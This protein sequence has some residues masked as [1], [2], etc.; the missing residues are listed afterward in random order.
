MTSNQFIDQFQIRKDQQNQLKITF[1]L[2]ILTLIAI[3]YL[4]L[5]E[6]GYPKSF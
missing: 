4:I 3:Q 6:P 5:G 2:L 1:V